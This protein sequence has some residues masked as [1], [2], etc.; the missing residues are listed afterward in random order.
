MTSAPGKGMSDSEPRELR[1][2]IALLREEVSRLNEH[3]FIRIQNS[4]LRLLALQ[5]GR[6]LVFGL[7]TV[8]GASI[9]VSVLVYFL[10]QIELLPII[11]DWAS[12]IISQIEAQQATPATTGD[13]GG[14]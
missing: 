14:R 9:L 11:G 10:S 12:E 3:R 5:F 13:G 4:P 8:I 6:G 2:E 1:E 7:G